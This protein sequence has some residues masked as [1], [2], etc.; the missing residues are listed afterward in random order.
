MYKPPKS[1]VVYK[2][3][4]NGQFPVR[5]RAELPIGSDISDAFNNQDNEDEETEPEMI[6]PGHRKNRTHP[7]PVEVSLRKIEIKYRRQPA[8]NV[9]VEILKPKKLY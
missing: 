3:Q 9:I 8:C 1:V 6:F 4:S 5:R 7:G 2:G